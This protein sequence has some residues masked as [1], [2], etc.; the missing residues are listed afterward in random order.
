MIDRTNAVLVTQAFYCDLWSS[1]IQWRI[2]LSARIMKHLSI[3]LRYKSA[4]EHTQPSA[5]YIDTRH[6]DVQKLPTF[7]MTESIKVGNCVCVCVCLCV[8]V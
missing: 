2:K 3:E 8:C 5:L 1:R 6:R 4:L 7:L